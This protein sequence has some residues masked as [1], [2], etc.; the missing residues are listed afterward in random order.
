[1]NP[2]ARPAEA[3]LGERE[4]KPRIVVVTGLSGS[5]KSTAIR[6]LEDCGYFC[7]DNLP[8]VLLPKMTE[9]AAA[10]GAEIHLLAIVIDAREGHF[11]FD[12]P[13]FIEETRRAGNAVE[14]VF[15]DS[16][17]EV[18]IRRFSETRRRHPLAPG[19]T[20]TEGIRLERERLADLRQLADQ[21]IDTSRLTVHELKS[22]VQSRF[23]TSPQG[24][25]SLSL[26]SF[27]YRYGIPAQADLVF[28]VRFL[29]NPY[30]V[31]ELKAFTG[32]DERVARYVLEREEAR[33]F[34]DKLIDLCDFLV[35]HFQREG[36][37]YLT[38]AI[39]C[40]GGKHRSVAIAHALAQRMGEK[41]RVQVWDRDSEK[42]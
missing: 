23:A 7:I 38:L 41:H 39:G 28:D 26:L 16:S 40:T 42:E 27:G 20:V 33:A 5:G 24:G 8:V 36:K 1:V 10:A 21:V 34:L 14:V 31:P 3:P 17:D 37:A 15:F 30:F 35:P 13:R 18:L 29:P 22:V 19:G 6:A 2:P 11:L 25:P 9:L 32:R 4:P 12:A